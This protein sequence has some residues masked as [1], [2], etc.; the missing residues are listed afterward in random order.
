MKETQWS[1]L[2]SGGYL[3]IQTAHWIASTLPL[4]NDVD[5]LDLHAYPLILNSSAEA[6]NGVA[7]RSADVDAGQR[8]K[9]SLRTQ[10]RVYR[11]LQGHLACSVALAFTTNSTGRFDLATHAYPPLQTYQSAGVSRNGNGEVGTFAAQT[12]GP[13]IT[14]GSELYSFQQISGTCRALLLL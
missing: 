10:P 4:K 1:H 9:K 11:S 2:G 6:S 13:E 12:N 7:D 8:K 5:S 14:L 3:C